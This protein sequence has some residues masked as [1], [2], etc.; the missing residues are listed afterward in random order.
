MQVVECR[1]ILKWTYSFGYYN[2]DESIKSQHSAAVLKQQQEFFEFNQVYAPL[3]V[4]PE[5]VCLP[6]ILRAVIC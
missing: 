5:F 6:F 2:F 3:A 1:R 4:S